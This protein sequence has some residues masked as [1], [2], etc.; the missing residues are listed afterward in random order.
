MVSASGSRSSEEEPSASSL[1]NEDSGS[2][3]K[4]DEVD[5]V[6]QSSESQEED[7]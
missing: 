2:K 5:P 6:D 1:R 3:E 7:E 4:T